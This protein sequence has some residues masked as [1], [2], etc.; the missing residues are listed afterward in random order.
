MCPAPRTSSYAKSGRE[1]AQERVDLAY[2]PDG[3]RIAH[4]QTSRRQLGGPVV[5]RCHFVQHRVP[6][7]EIRF[8]RF[9]EGGAPLGRHVAPRPVAGPIVGESFGCNRPLTER[10]KILD[11]VAQFHSLGECID[12]AGLREEKEWVRLEQDERR[13]AMS[14]SR[15]NFHCDGAAERMTDKVDLVGVRGQRGLDKTRLIV[16]RLRRFRR[17]WRRL[18]VSVEVYG[19]NTVSIFQVVHQPA[20]LS[21]TGNAGMDEHH[22][23]T[24]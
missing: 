17:P 20:P 24:G 11:A 3:A 4:Q 13:D 9:C 5:E 22:R 14:Q 15:R 7:V 19:S 2:W 6:L 21:C 16:E 1:L 23:G 8:E 12:A 10:A 18:A